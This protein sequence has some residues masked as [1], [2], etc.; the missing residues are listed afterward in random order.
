MPFRRSY[1]R[2]MDRLFAPFVEYGTLRHRNS[3]GTLED[4]VEVQW[5]MTW[6][7]IDEA[8][9][10]TSNQTITTTR[11]N[12]ILWRKRQARLPNVGDQIVDRRGMVW[13]VL[14]PINHKARENVYIC[15]CINSDMDGKLRAL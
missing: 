8:T 14:S 11:R 7:P 4:C 10:G 6:D 3:D 5:K 13:E 2:T 12:W 1:F 15:P 9:E